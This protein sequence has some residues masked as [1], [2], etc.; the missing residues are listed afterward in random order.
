MSAVPNSQEAVT[1]VG[2]GELFL[3]GNLLLLELEGDV[4]LV[5]TWCIALDPADHKTADFSSVFATSDLSVKIPDGTGGGRS[6]ALGLYSTCLQRTSRDIRP[7]W[8]MA[9][10]VIGKAVELPGAL[11]WMAMPEDREFA[12]GVD[13]TRR[14]VANGEKAQDASGKT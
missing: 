6:V 5:K 1:S 10:A 4:V 14:E 3:E 11:R 7:D 13:Q 8:V 2:P 9:W 12:V